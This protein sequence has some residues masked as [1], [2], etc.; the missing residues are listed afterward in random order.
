M[1]EMASVA[2]SYAPPSTR[3]PSDA[4]AWINSYTTKGGWYRLDQAQRRLETW[5]RTW[6]RA[7]GTPLRVVRQTY[8]DACH[9]MASG[10]T[11]AL[12]KPVGQSPPRCTRRKCS[13]T[14]YRSDRSQSLTSS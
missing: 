1:A 6:M 5:V 7:P 9:A 12:V 2:L 4:S 3:L 8:E 11:K 14:S 10:F 13:A